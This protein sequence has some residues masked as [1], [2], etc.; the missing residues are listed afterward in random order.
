M[1]NGIRH[2]DVREIMDRMHERVRQRQRNSSFRATVRQI[3]LAVMYTFG[4]VALTKL[5][6]KFLNY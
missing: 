1:M 2:E 3:L 4:A 6:K 5:I